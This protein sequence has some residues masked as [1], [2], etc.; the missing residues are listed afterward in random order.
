MALEHAAVPTPAAGEVLVRVRAVRVCGSGPSG[1][2]GAISLRVPPLVMGHECGGEAVARGAGVEAPAE[3]ARVAVHPLTHSGCCEQ[4]V[5]G[6]ENLCPV[7]TLI[8]AQWSRRLRGACR[9]S[10]GMLPCPSRAP[11]TGLPEPRRSLRPAVRARGKAGCS[12]SGR[13]S[14][15]HPGRSV[16]PDGP[17]GGTGGRV[18]GRCG[19]RPPQPAPRG[20][21]GARRRDPQ[22]RQRGHGESPCGSGSGWA[23]APPSSASACR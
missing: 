18:P 6:T 14:A 13:G 17:G 21:A 16:G 7:R 20:A 2:V 10:G 8:G 11:G 19:V 5:A 23:P 3:R 12:E 15:D 1:Y 22:P 4:C 9:R